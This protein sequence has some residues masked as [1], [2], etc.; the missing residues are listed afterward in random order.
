[1][2]APS[3]RFSLPGSRPEGVRDEREA[4]ARVRDMFTGIAPRYDFLN[5]FLSLS[6][7]R[8]WRR[9]TAAR[10]TEIVRRADA[11]VL[12]LC[13][14]T[15]DLALAFERA[16]GEARGARSANLPRIVGIDFSHAMLTRARGKATQAR[17]AARFAEA[18]ALALPFRDGAF[19]LL[20]VA[21]GFRNL[22]NYTGGLA[23]MFRVLRPGGTA[24][25][26]E[27]SEPSGALFGRAYRFYFKNILPRIGRAISGNATAYAY[28]PI[29]VSKFPT[30]E[31]LAS[32]MTKAGF[33][34]VRFESWTAGIVT[35]HTGRK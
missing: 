34:D 17:Y 24:A 30:P 18:D 6:F 3:P 12:D 9:R 14:G 15:G 31:E 1:M 35:L 23:E 16:A 20:A 33:S 4:S 2:T 8:L 21:F 11:C 22:A 19:D 13:C 25:I 26:L 29:S 28:L 5:H 7:D 27:F 32:Q 10:F